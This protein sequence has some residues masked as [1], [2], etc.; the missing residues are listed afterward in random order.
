MASVD[1]RGLV[2]ASGS[3]QTG[4]TATAGAAEETA[5]II[6]HTD[7]AVLVAFY[8][9]TGGDAWRNNGGWLSEQPLSQWH[10]VH[11]DAR[12][13]V[14]WLWLSDNDLTGS[15]PPELGQLA[16][17]QRLYLYRNYLKGPIPPELGQLAGLQRL[18]LN[19]N[20]LTGSIPPEL[21]QLARLQHLWLDNNDLTGSIPRE[22]GQ[23]ASLQRL[24]LY[25]NYLKGPI[26]PE[27]GQLA[28]LQRLYL[29]DNNLTGSIPRELGQLASLQHLYLYGNDLTGTI[30]PEL[31]RLADLV[32]LLLGGNGLTGPIPP[33]LGKLNGLQR[34]NLRNND[35]TGSIPAELGKLASL[36][37]LHVEHN[38][39]MTGALPSAMTALTKLRSLWAVYTGLCAM[40][41]DEAVRKWLDGIPR[42]RIDSCNPGA[43]YLT[44]A[45][46]TRHQHETVPLVAAEKALLRVF[47][48]AAK[49]T[50]EHIPD[51]RATF[52]V[53]GRRVKEIDVPGKA[54]AIPTEVD[55]GDLS[56][57][58]NAEVPGAT[59]Q[60]GL[61]VVVEVD[62]VDAS[63]GIPRRIPAT[64]RLKIPVDSVPVFKLTLIPFLYD[65]DPD[66]SIIDTVD[67]MAEDPE[68]HNLFRDTRTLLPVESLDVTA[69]AP[70]EIDSDRGLAVLRATDALRVAE[71]GSGYYK[72]MMPS[73]S[74][75]G[76]VAY[77]GG[78]SSASRTNN[79]TIAHELGHSMSLRHAPCG[80]AG[81]V[82]PLF[83]DKDGRIGSWGYDFAAKRVVSP[84]TPDLMSYCG[85]EW[86][87]AYHLDK[88]FDH[89]VNDEGG[90]TGP[91][92]PPRAP[93][94]SLLLWGG[95]GPDGQPYLEPVFVMDAPPALPA[96]GGDHRLRGLDAAGGELF[97]LPFDMPEIADG[98]G[99]SAFAFA[100]PA[101]PGWAESLASV[102]LSG[103][104]GSVTLDGDGDRPTAILRDPRTGEIRA[105][106]RDTARAQALAA[107]LNADVLF[108][109]GIPDADAWRR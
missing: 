26:P 38:A 23:L 79:G 44:Q 19:D 4:I 9:A 49:K 40:S 57:S 69:H 99:S 41:D 58:A 78:W 67:D 11:T 7:R 106:L 16:G 28:G 90:K 37:E 94:R 72:G 29:S 36:E 105:I 45:V 71:G 95:T 77:V 17:L 2:T 80:G 13:Y 18:Y 20:D 91:P 82:D 63:L 89:R 32:Y 47:L 33:G 5:R 102:T 88:A 24:Y 14:T 55:E 98:D 22:L 73:F 54:T 83:P 60:P 92:P 100:L 43:V 12:G 85:P 42:K 34:L 30:P 64:G 46:Q 65:A 25:R 97:S 6:V 86:I 53:G 75:V 27:L 66:S 48:V 87:S 107:T 51:V 96:D 50:D 70:V 8:N 74:D 35:L 103:P 109:R 81:G 31:G 21:G 61:E 101:D 15:I 1:A 59:V 108:S 76:G 93:A 68:D 62:S 84:R 10:G 56:K 3:G 39:G 104:G 52:Y